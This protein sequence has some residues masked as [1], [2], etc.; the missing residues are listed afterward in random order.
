MMLP[1]FKLSQSST[2]SQSSMVEKKPVLDDFGLLLCDGDSARQ[3]GRT[4]RVNNMDKLQQLIDALNARVQVTQEAFDEATRSYQECKNNIDAKNSEL[5]DDFDW[6]AKA[7]E[8]SEEAL[9]AEVEYRQA[10]S[11]RDRVFA[12]IDHDD[13]S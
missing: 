1:R 3:R 11:E 5:W 7:N 8:L 2:Q 10:K 12:L 4:W 6:E 9:E 13:N